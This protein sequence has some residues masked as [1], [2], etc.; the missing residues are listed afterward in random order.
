MEQNPANRTEWPNDNAVALRYVLYAWRTVSR[1]LERSC[2]AETGLFMIWRLL[3]GGS[4]PDYSTF[5]TSKHIQYQSLY[6]TE[7]SCYSWGHR[8]EYAGY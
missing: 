2:A 1:W 8:G 6:I 7:V 4:H 5:R 3:A